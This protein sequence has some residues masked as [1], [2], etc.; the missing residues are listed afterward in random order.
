[1]RLSNE[2]L[3]QIKVL[4]KDKSLNKIACVLSLPKSTVQYWY[5]NYSNYV[6]PQEIIIDFGNK[7]GIGE[8]I[9]IFAGDGN[10]TKDSYYKH[11]IRIYINANDVRYVNY[12]RGLFSKLFGKKPWIYTDV[13][14]NVTVVR[15]VSKE[16]IGFI[17]RYLLWEHTKTKTVRLVGGFEEDKRFSTGFLRGLIDTDGYIDVRSRVAKFATISN[18]L[19]DNIET[20]LALLG[21]RFRRYCCIDKR[22]N[23]NPIF[24]IT[25]TKD[26]DKFINVIKPC[27]AIYN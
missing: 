9:G 17:Y 24:R 19:A 14:N 3:T 25:I 11:Q 16:L 22:P 21:I 27:H 13:T 15:F 1:M 6:H 23:R 4:A 18:S 8:F 10:Y 26:F 2:Q 20:A 5:K 7:E 12:L